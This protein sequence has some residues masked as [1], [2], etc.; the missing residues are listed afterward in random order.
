MLFC[1]KNSLALLNKLGNKDV[2]GAITG[3]I[4]PKIFSNT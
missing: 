1:K 4:G 3:E 2:F